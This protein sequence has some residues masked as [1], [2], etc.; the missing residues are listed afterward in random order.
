MICHLHDLSIK[1]VGLAGLVPRS[2]RV[3]VTNVPTEAAR[4]AVT[5]AVRHGLGSILRS[6]AQGAGGGSASEP[7]AAAAAAR[8]PPG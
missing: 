8:A 4:R 6:A 7:S 2:R 1:G 3:A 5:L